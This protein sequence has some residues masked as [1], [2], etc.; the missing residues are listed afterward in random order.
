LADGNP[1]EALVINNKVSNICS[2][3]GDGEANLE[4]V[5][6]VVVAKGLNLASALSVLPSSTG[7]IGW[8]LPAKELAEDVVPVGGDVDIT[9]LGS[10]L[11]KEYVVINA[12]YQS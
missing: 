11:T 2:G 5:C 8:R 3:G 4:F 12:G 10:D 1:L 6:A 7:V 9:V